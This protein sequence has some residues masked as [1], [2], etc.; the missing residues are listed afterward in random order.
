LPAEFPPLRA[1]ETWPNNLPAQ[2]TSFVG[3]AQEC[4]AVAELLASQRLV[5]LT[6]PGGTGKTRLALHVAADRLE[7]YSNGVWLVEL[8]P[9]ADPLLVPLALASVL[10]LREEAGR[11]LLTVLTIIEEQQ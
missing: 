3:R 10:G 4:A 8:A 2:L 5:T 7:Q 6:G 11:P 1:L 9:L